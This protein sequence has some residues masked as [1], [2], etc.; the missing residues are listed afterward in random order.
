V[1][2]L[3]DPRGAAETHPSGS[4]GGVVFETK[5]RGYHPSP[6]VLP[7]PRLSETLAEARPALIL[8][9]APPGF[10]KTT[11]LGQWRELDDRQFAWLTADSSDN[12]PF[13]FWAGVVAAIRQVKRGFRAAAEIALRSARVDVLDALV[14]LIVHEL[15]AIKG[16][17]VLVLDDYQLIENPACHESLAFFLEWKPN[18]V[19]VAVATRADPPIPISKLR[20][21][22]E[23][24]ELRAVDLCFTAEEEATFLNDKLRLELAPQTLGVLHDRTEGWPAGVYLASLSLRNASDQAAFV[25]GFGG[26]NRHVVDY[27]TEVVLAMLDAEQ[28]DFLV[29]TSILRT[30]CAPLCDAVTARGGSAEMLAELERANLFLIPLDD[31]RE[32]YRYHPLFAGLLQ[33]R[34]AERG[35]GAAQELHRRASAWL[36]DAGY[37]EEAVR[38]AIAVGEVET[39]TNLVV[40][41]WLSHPLVHLGRGEMVLQWLE[42]FPPRAVREDRRLA[43]VNAW[44]LSMLHRPEEADAALEIVETAAPDEALPDG[45]SFEAIVALL[46]A[47]FPRDNVGRAM[48]AATQPPELESRL[49]DWWQPTSLFA[50]GWAQYRAGQPEDASRRLERAALLGGRLQQWLLVS[51]AQGILARIALAAGEV[52]E[53]EV[54]A[55]EAVNIVEARRLSEEPGSGFA[56]VALGAVRARQGLVDQ[57]AELIECGLVRLRARGA[58]LDLADALLVLAPV[59]RALGTSTEARA[60]VESAKSL[61]EASPD[62]GILHDRLEDVARAL[63]PAH[64]RIEGD[65]DLTERELEVLRYLAEGLPKRDIGKVLFLS[66]NTI[67]S[68]T[69]SIYQK[70]RVSSRQAAIER[71]RELGAL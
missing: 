34:L 54:W 10:G 66:Y 11:L 24:L 49:S 57:A 7:R 67:H 4:G 23:L 45:T 58:Q 52:E 56:Y 29:E 1:G 59:Q 64:R 37:T 46:R 5:L 65:S 28:R 21:T 18:T 20:A 48:E 17:I 70:L 40:E 50:G 69:K 60:L 22:G 41:K 19:E 25:D 39:A 6:E 44:A 13:V 30:I 71:A 31:H 38:H 27:L 63:T 61:I 51:A 35:Q 62:P 42:P 47:C 53:A 68:H 55:S 32:W 33:G 2:Q 36:A 3:L 14:P 12:D 43:L 8:L 15:E 16:E 9:A 26:S